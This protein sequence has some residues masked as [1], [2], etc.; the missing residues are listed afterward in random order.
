MALTTGL[1]DALGIGGGGVSGPGTA[2]LNLGYNLALPYLSQGYG[3]IQ[4]GYGQA[5]PFL[6]SQYAAAQ[7]YL[8]N[9]YNAGQA[10]VNQLS[11][12][13][14]FGPGGPA[15]AQ[16]A[17][18]ATPGYQFTK[19]QGEG[20][21]D[22]AAAA[23]GKLGSGSLV[24][25]LADYT[26]G[27]ASQT[28]QNAVS[29]LAP[30]TNMFT[31]GATNLGNLFTGMGTQGANL[32]TAQGRDLAAQLNQMGSL[33]WNLGAGTGAYGAQGGMMNAQLG[34][35]LLSG[36]LGLGGSLFGGLGFSD[37][38]LKT[39]VA[40]VGELYDGSNV[41]A[42]KYLWDETPRVGLMAHEVEPR[43]PDAVVEHPSGYK[44]VDYAKATRPA[45]ALASLMAA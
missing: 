25:S 28:Y 38:R 30:Y 37:E 2:G 22:A 44:M 32:M 12:L 26:S 20:A 31:G 34:G 15:G 7:P 40:K 5:L 10:G 4:Q 1:F 43:T 24:K 39:D 19:T 42:F 6:S 13:L 11:N 9:V 17:L 14:G 23:S 21:L 36:L 33:G 8:S 18:E 35:N 27:L 45:A 16:T 29:N 3:Q 41:Y